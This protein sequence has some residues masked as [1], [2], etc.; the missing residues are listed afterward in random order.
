MQGCRIAQWFKRMFWGRGLL[1]TVPSHFQ[2]LLVISPWGSSYLTKLELFHLA[3]HLHKMAATRSRAQLTCIRTSL[4]HI[5]HKKYVGPYYK[6]LVVIENSS[7]V[8]KVE[9]FHIRKALN[10]HTHTHH[11]PPHSPTRN[12]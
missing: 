9:G 7:E 10:T 2:N 3:Y 1:T 4:T 11:L 12:D 6:L 8:Q 5:A